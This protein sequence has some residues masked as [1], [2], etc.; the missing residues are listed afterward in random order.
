LARPP[1]PPMFP[2][3]PHLRDRVAP[4]TSVATQ[5]RLTREAGMMWSF[6]VASLVLWAFG[7]VSSHTF[8]GR[9]HLLLGVAIGVVVVRMIQGHRDPLV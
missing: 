3:I 9:I 1:K 6:F 5:G 7:V 2:P 8:G 4:G